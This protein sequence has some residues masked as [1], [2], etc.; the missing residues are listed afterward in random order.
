[1]VTETSER[2][3]V[4]NGGLIYTLVF[5]KHPHVYCIAVFLGVPE[6]E[7]QFICYQKALVFYLHK[8]YEQILEITEYKGIRIL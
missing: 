4:G 8:Y 2:G 1:M 3:T 6:A 5:M 7:Q